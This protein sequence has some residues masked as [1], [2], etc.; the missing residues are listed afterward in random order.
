[1]HVRRE[2]DR[3]ARSERDRQMED[4][5]WQT[6]TDAL[7]RMPIEDGDT[8]LDLGTGSGYA[9]RALAEA[10]DLEHGIGIDAS[11]AMACN[12][13]EYTATDTL[14]YAVGDFEELPIDTGTVDHVWSMEAFFF[15]R[16]PVAAIDE[17][18]RVLRPDGTFYCAVN[19]YEESEQS[20]RWEDRIDLPMQRL[21]QR[22]YRCVFRD[23]G[24]AVAA[25]ETIPNK[26]IDIPPRDA[27]PTDEFETRE[28]MVDRF[29]TWGTLL[30]VGVAP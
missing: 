1:M 6:A 19:F 17:I 15:A 4:E 9:L 2:F 23:G 3:W 21:S 10:H 7:A 13:R 14:R 16:D 26:E 8:V 5:H 27:F 24:L 11:P 28:A 25:Q 20:H 22:E 18:R 29:R 12:A 30:T